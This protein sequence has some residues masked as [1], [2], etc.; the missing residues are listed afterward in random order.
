MRTF[1]MLKKRGL[2]GPVIN[3]SQTKPSTVSSPSG[4]K[5]SGNYIVYKVNNP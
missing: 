4:V 1:V 2:L 3:K 5:T